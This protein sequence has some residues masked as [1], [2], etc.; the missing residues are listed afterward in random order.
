M[1]KENILDLE[2]KKRKKEKNGRL[3]LATLDWCFV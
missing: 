1:E 3:R 2:K